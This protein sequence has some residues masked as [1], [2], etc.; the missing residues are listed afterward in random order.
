[1]TVVIDG[2]PHRTLVSCHE[3]G[4]FTYHDGEKWVERVAKVLW[5]IMATLP[6]DE[7]RRVER[8]Q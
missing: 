2:V 1:M 3:D 6:E 5:W 4:S 8:H 7:R